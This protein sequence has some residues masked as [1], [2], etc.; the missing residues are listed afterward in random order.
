M[1]TGEN[2][3]VDNVVDNEFVPRLGRGQGVSSSQKGRGRDEVKGIFERENRVRPEAFDLV[4]NFAHD[5]VPVS[6]PLWGELGTRW[7][8]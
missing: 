3:P 2:S 7:G 5:F 4:P 1:Q 8:R 6:P